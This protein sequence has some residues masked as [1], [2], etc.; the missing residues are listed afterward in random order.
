MT[1]YG[2][3]FGKTGLHAYSFLVSLENACG[4]KSHAIKTQ[5]FFEVALYMCTSSEA[6]QCTVFMF[7][8]LPISTV[9]PPIVSSL[10]STERSVEVWT[11]LLPPLSSLPAVKCAT[12]LSSLDLVVEEKGYYITPWFS[13]VF[14]LG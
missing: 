3:K 7:P 8:F 11:S 4:I 14:S 2:G 9:D 10:I 6:H 1:I 13:S 12:L 5:A